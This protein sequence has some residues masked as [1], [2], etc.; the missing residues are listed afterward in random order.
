M[1]EVKNFALE[2]RVEYGYQTLYSLKYRLFY[3]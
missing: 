2:A 1:R 3:R